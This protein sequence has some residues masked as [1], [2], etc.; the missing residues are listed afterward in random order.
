M[1]TKQMVVLWAGIAASVLM[2]LFP[3][4]TGTTRGSLRGEWWGD[5]GRVDVNRMLQYWTIV[6]VVAGGLIYTT[7][8]RVGSPV[9]RRES[10]AICTYWKSLVIG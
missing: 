5:C 6:T 3:P 10:R 9:G 8:R 4:M 1:K 7:R 2:G